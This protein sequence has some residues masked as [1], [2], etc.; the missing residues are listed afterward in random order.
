M[1]SVLSIRLEGREWTLSDRDRAR[2]T[3]E[4]WV[5]AEYPFAERG[6]GVTVRLDDRDPDQWWR[7]TIGAT[8]GQGDVL[9]TVI[10]LAVRAGVTVFELRMSVVPGGA[11]VSPRLR[12]VSS[13]AA[14]A[15]VRSMVARC[16]FFDAGRRVLDHVIEITDDIGAQDV[17]AFCEAPSRTLPV[18]V[19]TVPS[20]GAAVF[21]A[22]RL[23]LMLTG[24]AHVY[25][26]D[27]DAVRGAFNRFHGANLLES[28]GLTVIWPDLSHRTWSGGSLTDT[29]G[30]EVR[31]QCIPLVTDVAADSL[32]PLRPPLF[33]RMRTEEFA[34]G[35]TGASHESTG[36]DTG[37]DPDTV[38]WSDYRSALDG[39][40]ETIERVDELEEAM[41]EADR[42]IAEKQALLDQGD[43]I[44]DQLI[45]QNTELSLLMGRQPAGLV[46]TNA[47]DAVKQARELCE[48]LTFHP[49]AVETA[50]HLDGIDATR[51]LQDLV[52]L[53]VVAGDWQTGR[54]NR[55]SL[56]ISCRGIGLD[57]AAGISDTAEQ[58]FGSEYAFTW[59]GRTEYAVA[60]I[61]NGRG[62]RLYRVHVFFDE[63]T[64]QVVVA[65]IG[66]HLRGK[67]D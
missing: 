12:P 15:L 58:K 4:D 13:V 26:L 17:A 51:L 59:R 60:H 62:P 7:Y 19:E 5:E 34:T 43:R 42:L 49:R 57:F 47:L 1:R 35:G 9:S 31:R 46:A 21:R 18:I 27:G 23:P 67:R 10:T 3:V 30:D 40:Q 16:Q 45:L 32:G 65:Y 36:S 6:P 37:A 39:W 63:E 14:R 11:R 53:N 55:A 24:L 2:R 52:R 66:R 20:K 44:V 33:R 56:K 48:N 64:H 41:A 28:K 61:R 29:G 25:V 54:I 8:V 38:P 22:D 50:T